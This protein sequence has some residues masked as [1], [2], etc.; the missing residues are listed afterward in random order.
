MAVENKEDSLKV[1][2][3]SGDKE[4]ALGLALLYTKNSKLRGWWKNVEI[5]IWG[6]ASMLAATDKDVQD[7]IRDLMAIG[8]VVKACR[9]CAIKF[10]VEEEIAAIGVPVL[11]M[12]PQLS[13][14][15]HEGFTVLSV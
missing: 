9:G 4:T 12:G 8:I 7:E 13:E 1:L 11:S 2:W 10:G 14:Y 5:I 3:H 15:L 6:G